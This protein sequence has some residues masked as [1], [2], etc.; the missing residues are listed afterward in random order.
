MVFPPFVTHY[1]TKNPR[2]PQEKETGG[3]FC[4]V[5]LFFRG[6]F[7]KTR[8]GSLPAPRFPDRVCR[9][10]AARRGAAAAGMK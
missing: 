1:Y 5:F 9:S 6:R 10:R 8:R 3:P 7:A 2:F 4:G